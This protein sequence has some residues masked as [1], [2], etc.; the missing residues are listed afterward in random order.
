MK[1]SIIIIII[2]F[3]GYV[4][5]RAQSAGATLGGG[6]ISGDSPSISS[7]SASLFLE[8]PIFYN[9]LSMR[10]SFIYAADYNQLLPNST[11]KYNPFVKGLSLTGLTTQGFTGSYYLN[12]GIGLLILNDRI[13]SN[14][15]NI[16][17]GFVISIG[18]GI[19][20]RKERPTG[21][22]VGAGTDFGFTFTRTY[23]KYFS[24]HLTGQYFL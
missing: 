22:R 23:A 9:S 20:L 3:S 1:K 4:I 8:S 12:E 13:F 24:L 10:L 17:Y 7:Y 14:T 5:I 19:D 21:F 11:T 6:S 2:L 15:D 16:D 18:A